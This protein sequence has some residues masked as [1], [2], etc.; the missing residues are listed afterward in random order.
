MGSL[1][2]LARKAH[3]EEKVIQLLETEIPIRV[4]QVLKSMYKK[5]DR[6]IQA[7]RLLLYII[8]SAPP[9]YN[10]GLGLREAKQMIEEETWQYFLEKLSAKDILLGVE[11]SGA[12]LE[13][14]ENKCGITNV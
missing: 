2:S 4:G 7:I 5:H 11:R 8:R 9:L 3:E 10:Y 1:R 6:K 12:S 14:L 13:T